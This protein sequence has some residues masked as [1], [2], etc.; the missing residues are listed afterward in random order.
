M[1]RTGVVPV[2][3]SQ[4]VLGPHVAA[5]LGR[6]AEGGAAWGAAREGLHRGG[7]QRKL[8]RRSGARQNHAEGLSPEPVGSREPVRNEQEGSLTRKAAL[9]A[10]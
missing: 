4:G 7:L 3:R 5:A 10:E 6:A 1:V 8:S 9:A 2:G